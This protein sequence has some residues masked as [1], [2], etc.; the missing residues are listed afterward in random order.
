MKGVKCRLSL[1]FPLKFVICWDGEGW[2]SFLAVFQRESLT[3][4]V[5]FEDIVYIKQ[6]KEERRV[7]ILSAKMHLSFEMLTEKYSCDASV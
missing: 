2:V 6:R 3:R 4:N 1:Q 7:E 5:G